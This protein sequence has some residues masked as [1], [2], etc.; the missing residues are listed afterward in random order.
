MTA[1]RPGSICYVDDTVDGILRMLHAEH[2]GPVNIGNPHE[3]SVL[4]LAEWIRELAGSTSDL[5]F[6]AR[7]EDDP[8]VRQPDI[9]LA[10]DVLAWEPKT[11][12]EDGLR[13]TIAWFREHP[14]LVEKP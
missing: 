4:E 12:V 5:S 10:R 3:L 14:E 13:R 9:S 8:R 2:P 1:G 7:P 11:P 6:I